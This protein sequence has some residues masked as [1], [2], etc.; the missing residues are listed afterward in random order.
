MRANPCILP[1]FATMLASCIDYGGLGAD[2]SAYTR[3]GATADPPDA[4]PT[5]ESVVKPTRATPP[6]SDCAGVGA[7]ADDGT[8]AAANLTSCA[9]D[10]QYDSTGRTWASTLAYC[11]ALGGGYRLATKGEA[12]ELVLNPAICRTPLLG[13]WY[14]WTSTCAG[15]GQAWGV[16]Y[17]GAYQYVV[18]NVNFALCVR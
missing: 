3:R 2:P 8:A 10:C 5:C 4:G 13:Y 14:T 9:L 17:R 11:T 6:T 15:G 18:G 1:A 7:S 16:D 12:L